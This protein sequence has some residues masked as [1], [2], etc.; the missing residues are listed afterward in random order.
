MCLLKWHILPKFCEHSS[1]SKSIIPLWI[2]LMCVFKLPFPLYFLEHSAGLQQRG[3]RFFWTL[4]FL[5]LLFSPE[6]FG[7]DPASRGSRIPHF[8]RR[9]R[10]KKTQ[11][12]RRRRRNLEKIGFLSQKMAFFGQKAKFGQFWLCGVSSSKIFQNLGNF[13]KIFG[14]MKLHRQ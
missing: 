4:V 6:V 11:C 14:L 10:P 3:V 1:H 7:V 9:R 8:G 5:E 12:R 2:V 13:R